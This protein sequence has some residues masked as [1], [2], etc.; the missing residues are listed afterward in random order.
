M[1]W[2]DPHMGELLK[3]DTGHA[4]N[5]FKIAAGLKDGKHQGTNWHDGDFYKWMESAMYVYAIN[6]DPE[7]LK[8]LDDIVEVIGKAQQADGYLSTQVI[9]KD[10]ERWTNRQHH[11][12]YNSGHLLTS[13]CI[14]HRV[15]GQR[16]FLDI[17]IKQQMNDNVTTFIEVLLNQELGEPFRRDA[18]KKPV[19]VA[20]IDPADMRPQEAL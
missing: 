1:F 6:K 13:A 10:I 5:N 16:N 20:G 14:H 4:Y 3:G 15:T 2:N 9:L 17:A 11:E 12:L 8:E 19:V 18:M 7:I